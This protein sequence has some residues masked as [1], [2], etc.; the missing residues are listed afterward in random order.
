[1]ETDDLCTQE[2]RAAWDEWVQDRYQRN[3]PIRG[4][5]EIEGLIETCE[6]LGHDAAIEAI[7]DAICAGYAT[8]IDK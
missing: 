1:M 2:F 3:F 7:D 6:A 5:R 4:R 8:I